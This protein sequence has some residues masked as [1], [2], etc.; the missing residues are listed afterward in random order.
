MKRRVKIS[1]LSAMVVVIVALLLFIFIPRKQRTLLSAVCRVDARTCY[2]LRLSAGDTLFL[3]LRADSLQDASALSPTAVETAESQSGAFVSNV[4]DLITSDVLIG[5]AADTLTRS[6]L[7]KRLLG[8]D[9]LLARR[10]QTEQSEERELNYYAR[11][12]SVVDDGYNDVMA[13]RERVISRRQQTDTALTKVR[14]LLSERAPLSTARLHSRITVRLPQQKDSLLA[15]VEARQGG[16]L[17]VRLQ[18]ECLPQTCRRFSVYRWGVHAMN[19]HLY[20]FNDFGSQSAA[21]SPVRTDSDAERYPASEGGVWVNSSGHLSQVERMGQRVGNQEVIRLMRQVHTWPMWW[22]TNLVGWVKSFT[23][24][25]QPHSSMPIN[26]VRSASVVYPD[27]SRYVGEVSTKPSK[28]VP[29]RQGYGSLTLS[30]G[31]R[32]EGFWR[33]DTLI[34][35]KRMDEKGLYEGRMDSLYEPQGQGIFYAHSG[36]MYDG[37]WE[38]GRR[39]GHGFSSKGGQMVRC[40]SWKNGRFQGERMIYTSDRVYGIDLSRYQHE[41]GRR[42]FSIDWDHLRITSLGADRRI[43]GQVDYPVTFA[44]I[45]STEGRSMYNKYYASDLRQARAKGIAVGTYHFFT[46]TSSGAE[47]A[48]YFL[49]MSWI[50]ANDLPPVL[51]LEPTPAQIKQMGGDA[52]MFRQVLTWLRTVEKRR[53][54]RPVLYV[55]QLFVNNH[56]KNAPAELRDYDVWI[57]RYGEFKPY[58]KLLHWQVSPYGRVRGIHTEVDVNVFNGTKEDFETYRKTGRL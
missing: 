51:D 6:E 53:G 47:Q 46:A 3:T 18:T 34:R 2:A 31:V 55:G 44:Y 12:H 23:L 30:D 37:E 5:A 32:I 45:K 52:G 14:H 38:K 16:L 27:S 15:H 8:L 43:Q 57:A 24:T 56:L 40:G 7:H 33:A 25:R 28:N 26:V 21:T 50:A 1:L 35:G 9:T 36:E 39:D 58:V 22:V 20:A 17:L 49:K 19:S 4:G 29:L 13:Y 42:R 41:K 54:K 48:A 10:L 11:T